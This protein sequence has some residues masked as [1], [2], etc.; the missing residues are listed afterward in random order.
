MADFRPKTRTNPG[1][2]SHHGAM[3]YTPRLNVRKLTQNLISLLRVYQSVV[4]R[5]LVQLDVIR[6]TVASSGSLY[7]THVL[8]LFPLVSALQP[9]LVFGGV[10]GS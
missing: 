1:I 8:R 7:I 10:M 4:G 2:N 5:W 9:Y 6:S 3:V